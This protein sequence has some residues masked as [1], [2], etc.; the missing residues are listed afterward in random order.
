MISFMII[1]L[2]LLA[3]AHLTFIDISEKKLQVRPSES[4]IILS[5]KYNQYTSYYLNFAQLRQWANPRALILNIEGATDYSCLENLS[6]IKYKIL[7][8]VTF[9]IFNKIIF[10]FDGFQAHHLPVILTIH[11]LILMDCSLF[12]HYVNIHHCWFHF[13]ITFF[14]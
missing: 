5:L 12:I 2:L 14:F 8:T 13:C 1:F 6:V 7:F 9:L 3:H 11:I 10:R 4:D